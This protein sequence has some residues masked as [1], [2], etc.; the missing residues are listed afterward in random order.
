M[1]LQHCDTQKIVQNWIFGM[2]RLQALFYVKFINSFCNS[3]FFLHFLVKTLLL[4][5][6]L[7][8]TVWNY[9]NFPHCTIIPF[10]LILL[11]CYIR[12]ERMSEKNKNKTFWMLEFYWNKPQWKITWPLRCAH[13]S[14][15]ALYQVS[16]LVFCKSSWNASQPSIALRTPKTAKSDKS[17]KN[18]IQ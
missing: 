15:T 16:T 10:L 5:A 11:W 6:I 1:K 14:L 17:V 3:L 13:A 2:T 4:S 12:A 7:Q 18:K 9:K 8:F